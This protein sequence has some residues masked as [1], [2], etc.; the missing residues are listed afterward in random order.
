[1][2]AMMFA[3][4]VFP[5]PGGPHKIMDGN[6]LAREM[7]GEWKARAQ[8]LAE[9]GRQPGLAVIIAGN[10]PASSSMDRLLHARTDSSEKGH[11]PLC[12]ENAEDAAT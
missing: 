7:R 11:S 12:K 1:M 2:W 8:H 9:Q 4:V 5:V 10:N 3:M 6:L